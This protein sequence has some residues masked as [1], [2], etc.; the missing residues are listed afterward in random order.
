M[1][2]FSW[3]HQR[4]TGR[5]QTRCTLGRK[6]TP[7]F[8]PQLETLEG[9]DVPSTLTVLNN[10]DSGA[11]SL[12]AEIAA[13][14]ANDT[15][16]FAPSLNGQTIKLTSGELDITQNLTIQ[17]PGAG[18]LTISGGN[19]SRVFEVDGTAPTVTLSGLTITQGICTGGDGGGVF[20]SFGTV[21]IINCTLS[22]NYAG[23][24]AG[25]Y[26]DHGTVT[27]SNSTLSGNY[28]TY[29]GGGVCNS[30][31]TVTVSNSTLSGNQAGTYGGGLYNAEGSATLVNSTLSG[32]SA[33]QSGGIYTICTRRNL[34]MISN[35]V[36]SVNRFEDIYNASSATELTISDSVFSANVTGNILGPWTNGGGN[37]F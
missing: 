19:A 26:N 35:C 16:V 6:P 37:T 32:N 25:V 1:P 4:M 30:F 36:F 14:K 31:G 2:L 27:I 5:L 21:S 9:R 24:G 22:G 29:D 34:V 15:I 33:S 28:A 12:R 17:G 10:L 20:N 13:A 18:Q 23:Y 11:G 7:R 8:R 3:L